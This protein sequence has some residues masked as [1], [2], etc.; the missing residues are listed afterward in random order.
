KLAG[1]AWLEEGITKGFTSTIFNMDECGGI[2]K[3][4]APDRPFKR[5]GTLVWWSR[6]YRVGQGHANPEEHAQKLMRRLENHLSLAFHRFLSERPRKVSIE[7]DIFDQSA[8]KAGIP[9]ELDP[10]DPFGY[11]ETG[12][13]EFPAPMCL[14]DGYNDR[15]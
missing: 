15:I 3:Q 9:I 10:L 6:L 14:E 5:S 4:I 13:K 1:R 2:L 8:G 11:P 7:L 12:Q